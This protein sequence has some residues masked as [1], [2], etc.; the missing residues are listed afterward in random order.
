MHRLRL[1]GFRCYESAQ[2]D[3]DARPVVLTG[4]NGAGKTNL[5]EA[6]SLLAPGRGLRGARLDEMDRQGAPAGEGWT[7]AASVATPGGS[8]FST[9]KAGTAAVGRIIRS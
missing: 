4:V 8:R 5:L 1:T 6:I 3:L 7:V 2:L 9:G